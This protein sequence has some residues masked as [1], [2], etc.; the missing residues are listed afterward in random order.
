MWAD[1]ENADG[2]DCDLDDAAALERYRAA[3]AE[4]V[5]APLAGTLLAVTPIAVALG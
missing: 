2:T 3:R 4:F 1:C 5:W